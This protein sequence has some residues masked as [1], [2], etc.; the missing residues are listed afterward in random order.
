MNLSAFS[1]PPPHPQG[2]YCYRAP[3]GSVCSSLVPV[4]PG[5]QSTALSGVIRPPRP[6][7]CPT[8][9][10]ATDARENTP[11]SRRLGSF[12][13]RVLLGLTQ[14]QATAIAVHEGCT[15]RVIANNGHHFLLTADFGRDRIDLV[16]KHGVITD[17]G[18]F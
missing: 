7:W 5:A 14:S 13:A 4:G 18:V 2:S 16:V 8:S 12:D 9:S 6:V 17:V 15:V 11:N 10:R 1:G 3:A